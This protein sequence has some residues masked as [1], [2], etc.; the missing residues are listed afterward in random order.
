MKKEKTVKEVTTVAP[1]KAKTKKHRLKFRKPKT[2][3]PMIITMIYLF[4]VLVIVFVAVY[5]VLIAC[6]AAFDD[7]AKKLYALRAL[8]LATKICKILNI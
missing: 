2:T 5:P 7:G 3:N 1:K 4:R 8:F 6:T